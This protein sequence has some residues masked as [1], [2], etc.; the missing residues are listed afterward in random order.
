MTEASG[1]NDPTDEVDGAEDVELSFELD[2]RSVSFALDEDLYPLD[3]IYGA[4]YLFIDRCYVFLTRPRARVVGVRLRTKDAATEAELE[5]LAGE[6]GNELLNQT[7]RARLGRSTMRI[8]EYYMA[9]AFF[10][11]DTDSTISDLL[12][13]LDAEELEEDALE[14]PVPWAADKPKAGDAQEREDG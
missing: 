12:A 11:N 1:P 9:R 10:A 8:R 6:M 2:E 4:A 5:A 7:L 14:I 3:A 13:E